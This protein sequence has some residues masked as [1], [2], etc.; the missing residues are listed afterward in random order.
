M[1]Y[2]QK[3][4]KIN[5]AEL[6]FETTPELCLEE[7]K[8]FRSKSFS[9]IIERNSSHSKHKGLQDHINYSLEDYIVRSENKENKY[10]LKF[11]SRSYKH[12]TSMVKQKSFYYIF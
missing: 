2:I 12:E 1:S 8:F 11:P 4:M 5:F 3:T 9:P 6:K 10:G 7:A